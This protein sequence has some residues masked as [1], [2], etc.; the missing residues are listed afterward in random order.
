M[1]KLYFTKERSLWNIFFSATKCYLKPPG[2]FLIA[3]EITLYSI[4]SENFVKFS[5]VDFR[6]SPFDGGNKD[7]REALCNI[8]APSQPSQRTL[9][10][11]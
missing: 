8:K 10:E 9:L 7:M 3:S 11:T 5:S 6:R 4:D 2:K 1:Y